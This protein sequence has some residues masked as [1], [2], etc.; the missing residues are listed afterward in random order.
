MM[1]YNLTITTAI[2]GADCSG[3][4][5]ASET[6]DQLVTQGLAWS[7][8]IKETWQVMVAA[9]AYVILSVIFQVHTLHIL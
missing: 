4:K 2:V 7:Q 5:I 9:G 1:V 3:T 8:H 6:H